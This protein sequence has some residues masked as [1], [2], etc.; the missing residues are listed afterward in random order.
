[1]HIESREKNLK[2]EHHS[3]ILQEVIIKQEEEGSEA[4]GRG[5]FNR[6]RGPII[7]YN[8]NQPRHLA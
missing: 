5:G 1:M 7:C 8:C 6:G 2:E 4:T 3:I